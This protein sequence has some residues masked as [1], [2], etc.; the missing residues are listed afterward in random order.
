MNLYEITIQPKSGFGTP[1]K[2]DTLFGHF[3]WQT[4]HDPLL[5]KGGI[6]KLI[7]HY[8]K[9]PFAVF[10]S[11]FPK[12][13]E[14]YI[15]MKR[16]DMPLDMIFGSDSE[17]CESK[18]RSIKIKK[19][20]KW[21]IVRSGQALDVLNLGPFNENELF[22]DAEMARRFSKS[23]NMNNHLTQFFLQPHNS[24]NRLTNTTGSEKFAPYTQDSF[25][26]R[27]GMKLAV[28]VLIDE[29][30]TGY[31]SLRRAMQRIGKFGFGKDASIGL[32]RFAVEDIKPV[33]LPV[34]DGSADALYT[35]A[36]C[37][38]EKNFFTDVWFS[39]FTRFGKHGDQLASAR[40]PFKNPVIMADEGAVFKPADKKIFEKPYIGRAVKNVSKVLKTSVVQGYAPYL[41]VRLP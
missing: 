29:S 7:E 19:K 23:E 2:G 13:S 30:V 16:P 18:H 25:Y 41:P 15:L 38:P 1:L 12:L 5:V 4:A 40:N 36:P 32:G 33:N 34:T 24:I 39:P 11:A 8:E 17:N 35:L 21:M 37:V 20:K 22:T 3:C 31:D 14:D 28:F 6:D 27:T 26:Y 9:T 10:S